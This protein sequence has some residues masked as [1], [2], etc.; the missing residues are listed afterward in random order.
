MAP[1][2]F[3]TEILREVVADLDLTAK[4]K[5]K[6][7][8]AGQ[9]TAIAHPV[10]APSSGS[11][12]AKWPARLHAAS[13]SAQRLLDY[14]SLISARRAG[15]GNLAVMAS[16]LLVLIVAAALVVFSDPASKLSSTSAGRFSTGIV[17]AIL[18]SRDPDSDF[19]PPQLGALNPPS[20]PELKTTSDEMAAEQSAA[21]TADQPNTE[22][23][24]N[25]ADNNSTEADRQPTPAAAPS[26]NIA[27]TGEKTVA[28]HHGYAARQHVEEYQYRGPSSVHV[29][30]KENLFQFALERFGRSNWTIVEEICKANPTIRGPY[31]ILSRDQWVRIPTGIE[32]PASSASRRAPLT[33]KNQ[34]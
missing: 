16:I 34:R 5:P 12:R 1:G 7:Q 6:L 10:A 4:P 18:S 29:Q 8:V 31:D 25:D 13:N 28:A 32:T 24:D 11:W 15:N 21:S 27:P 17:N 9:S 26:L 14:E 33:E 3:E 23:E 22:A 19:L 2:E 20:P 30:R